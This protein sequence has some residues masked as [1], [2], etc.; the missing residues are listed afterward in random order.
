VRCCSVALQS[1]QKLLLYVKLHV[2]RPG[3]F[4]LSRTSIDAYVRLSPS[5]LL[6]YVAETSNP[7]VVNLNPGQQREH[8]SAVN[9]FTLQAAL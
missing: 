5:F 6:K 9:R 4:W 1:C 7:A 2:H 3:G 8:S